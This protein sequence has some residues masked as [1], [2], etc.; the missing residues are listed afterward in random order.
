MVS[1]K[2]ASIQGDADSLLS[3]SPCQRRPS[4]NVL[5][6]RSEGVSRFGA[7]S[8]TRAEAGRVRGSGGPLKTLHLGPGCAELSTCGRS[9]EAR[10]VRSQYPGG[11]GFR[12]LRGAAEGAAAV[13]G[14]SLLIRTSGHLQTLLDDATLGTTLE[15]RCGRA[16]STPRAGR[17]ARR[18]GRPSAA[19]WRAA[20]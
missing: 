8:L 17:A 1:L 14:T 5:H 18:G 12:D 9:G 13:A 6:V 20:R 3:L 4:G 10:G 19:G 15:R 7:P 2:R 11:P 16:E